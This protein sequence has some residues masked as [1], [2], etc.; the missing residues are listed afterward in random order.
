MVK[1]I[2]ARFICK[3]V[4]KIFHFYNGRDTV[5]STFLNPQNNFEIHKNVFFPLNKWNLIIKVILFG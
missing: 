4:M 5:P 1:Q 3:L 2:N